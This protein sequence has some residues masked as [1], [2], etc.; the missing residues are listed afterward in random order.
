M[1]DEFYKTF[2]LL[3]G[4]ARPFSPNSGVSV[5]KQLLLPGAV[6]RP[7][8]VSLEVSCRLS[9]AVLTLHSIFVVGHW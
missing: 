9:V 5:Q 8:W 2:I 3:S 1:G 7:I 4:C 6:G